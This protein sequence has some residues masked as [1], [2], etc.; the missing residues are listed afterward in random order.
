MRCRINKSRSLFGDVSPVS[1][2]V[3]PQQHVEPQEEPPLPK[4]PP[5]IQPSKPLPIQTPIQ[6]SKPLPKLE[7]PN[8]EQ[9]LIHAIDAWIVQVNGALMSELLKDMQSYRRRSNVFCLIGPPGSG[10]SVIL[11]HIVKQMKCD[12]LIYD[13]FVEYGNRVE[14]NAETESSGEQAGAKRNF[15]HPCAGFMSKLLMNSKPFLLIIDHLTSN[16][17]QF[18][19]LLLR[20]YEDHKTYMLP[21]KSVVL[22]VHS[23]DNYHIRNW[24][25]TTQAYKYYLRT[26][27]YSQDRD[28]LRQCLYPIL[29]QLHDPRNLSLNP[30]HMFLGDYRR[31]GIDL[32]RGFRSDEKQLNQ[33]ASIFD[34]TRHWV[35]WPTES[36]NKGLLY[37]GNRNQIFSMS[38]NNQTQRYDL[39]F[40]AMKTDK[41]RCQLFDEIVH[42]V[43]DFSNM[44]IQLE[45]DM[46]TECD[47][48]IRPGSGSG[49]GFP[50]VETNRYD[51]FMLAH[52]M[53]E[54]NVRLSKRIR[55]NQKPQYN[56]QFHH[57]P[58][59]KRHEES[60]EENKLGFS[61]SLIRTRTMMCSICYK[62]RKTICICK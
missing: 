54:S 7:L 13:E 40:P 52:A 55:L 62:N 38:A 10:K 26:S 39:F 16:H 28:R 43:E 3:Q 1:V 44:D 31:M 33:V 56:I 41:D 18:I 4:P 46:E 49:G 48:E 9:A 60:G 27:L 23:L 37:S 42:T 36:L 58:N 5:T 2:P 21:N 17:T 59:Q 34:L 51:V 35:A 8:L 50:L 57:Q 53:Y 25:R 47:V 22:L 15:K 20:E 14:K 12:F 32:V 61:R 30:I 45:G 11:D 24:V 19:Q 6:P 29:S